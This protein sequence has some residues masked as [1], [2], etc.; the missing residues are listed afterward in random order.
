MVQPLPVSRHITIQRDEADTAVEE[1]IVPSTLGEEDDIPIPDLTPEKEDEEIREDELGPAEIPGEEEEIEIPDF[2]TGDK[3]ECP[4][5]I[6]EKLITEEKSEG[7]AGEGSEGDVFARLLEI[8]A[9][10]PGFTPGIPGLGGLADV[11]GI[12]ITGVVGKGALWAWRKLPLSVRAWA[13]NQAIDLALAGTEFF[14]AELLAASG[15]VMVW[16]RAGLLGF[17]RRL[18]REDDESKVMMFEKYLR[19][20][21]GQSQ[22]FLLGYL[23]GLLWGFFVD[24]LV[25]IIQMVVDLVCLVLKFRSLLRR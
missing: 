10:G 11:L 2:D 9:T 1:P 19:S 24:G 4:Q 14:P 13:I 23:K 25:G 8:A 22:S 20:I 7:E 12:S 15:V 17:L 16:M 18:Q 6:P 21:L 5:L 3:G